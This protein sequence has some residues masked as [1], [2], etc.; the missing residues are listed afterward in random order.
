M[1]YTPKQKKTFHFKKTVDK[2][3]PALNEK[4]INANF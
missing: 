1:K 4:V 2:K 3:E